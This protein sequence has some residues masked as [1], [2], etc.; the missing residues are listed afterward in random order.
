M[1]CAMDSLDALRL[2]VEESGKSQRLISTQIG[3]HPTYLA[4]LIHSGSY[5]QID[6]FVSIAKACGCE[7][8]VRLPTKDIE[9]EGW[10]AQATREAH[11]S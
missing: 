9:I 11:L 6:T 1:G 4:S 3:R 10:D 2:M 7:V 5:P 8:I